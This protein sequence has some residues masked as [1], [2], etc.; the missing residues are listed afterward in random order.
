MTPT[1]NLKIYLHNYTGVNNIYLHRF[2]EYS[3]WVF[4][5]EST[6]LCKSFVLKSGKIK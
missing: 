2:Q 6:V 5:S 1:I 3:V 4:H